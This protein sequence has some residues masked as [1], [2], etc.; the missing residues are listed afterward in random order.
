MLLN[1]L[2]IAA[3]AIGALYPA[4]A[5]PMF[6]FGMVTFAAFNMKLFGSMSAAAANL[7]AGVKGTY[8]TV[9]GGTM[10]LWAAYPIMF[11]LCELTRTLSTEQE[12]LVYAI[13]DVP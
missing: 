13:L 4:C 12:V 6:I 7:G 10:A 8:T 2:C 11:F 1:A 5:W 9:A 3:G